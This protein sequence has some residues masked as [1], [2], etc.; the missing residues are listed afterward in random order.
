MIHGWT[1]RE[2]VR[3]GLAAI[4]R[5]GR[6]RT[7][8][9]LED[10]ERILTAAHLGRSWRE[11][12]ALSPR[13]LDALMAPSLT[14]PHRL[15]AILSRADAV[16]AIASPL[17][18]L[19]PGLK[20]LLRPGCEAVAPA[21]EPAFLRNRLGIGPGMRLIVYPGNLHPA[22]RAEI[23]SLYV[24]V[25]ILRRRG[26]DV[27]LVRT[28]QDYGPGADV[29][30]DRLKGVVSRELGQ[31]PRPLV[32]SLIAAADLLIQPGRADA[33]NRSRLPSK[34]PEFFAAGCPVILPAANLGLE[35]EDG[36]E[37]VVAHRGDGFDLADLAEPLLADPERAAAIGAAGR[38]FAQRTLNWDR[39]TDDLEA[40]Y[41]GLLDGAE[42]SGHRQAA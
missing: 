27:M 1:P 40:L 21:H 28:G 38:R 16:T 23:L 29:A 2:S 26:H 22:N 39:S 35:V 20:R 36:V 17:L 3:A 6:F 12:Q 4:H 11:L 14:H 15:A 34:L 18:N 9:H 25:Q 33:F 42:A 31:V 8:I 41:R 24:A 13:A 10:D 5:V 32:L 37:A 30:Y 19:A 7:L